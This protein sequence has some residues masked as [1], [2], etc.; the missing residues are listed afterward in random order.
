[1]SNK[2]NKQINI[3]FFGSSG[4]S[5]DVLN[6]LINNT[7]IRVCTVVTKKD[8][9]VGRNGVVYENSVAKFAT[10]YSIPVIKVSS[11]LKNPSQIGNI[12]EKI[13]YA[14]VVSFGFILPKEVLD[15]LPNKFINLHT[16]LLPNYR[17]ASP[18]HQSIINGDTVTGVSTMTI[19][20]GMD[21]GDVLETVEYKIDKDSTYTEV[22]SDLSNIGSKLLLTTLKRL[23]MGEVVS[24]PQDHTK[25]TYTK[26]ITKKDGFVTLTEKPVD[27]YNMYRAFIEW[28]GIYSTLEHLESFLDITTKIAN[29]QTIIKLKK[30]SLTNDKLHIE[31]VQLPNK[32]V[33]SIKDFFNGYVSQKS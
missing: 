32:P 21:E 5:V 23:N 1:M 16:S 11:L 18:I 28:P 2:T 20:E 33:I 9:K 24:K 8:K 13:D 31:Y 3:V 19:N 22:S 10:K 27:I 6:N 29:K 14:V 12:L 4:F 26:I 17:G 30:V 15:K 25:A 7:N